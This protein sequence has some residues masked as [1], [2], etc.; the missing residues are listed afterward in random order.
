MPMTFGL[1]ETWNL[2]VR[3]ARQFRVSVPRITLRFERLANLLVGRRE[4]ARHAEALFFKV[5]RGRNR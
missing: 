2:P 4:P 5:P 3:Q 1:I